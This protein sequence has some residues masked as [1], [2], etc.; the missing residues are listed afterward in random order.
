MLTHKGT[1]PLQTK[2]LK[3][4]RFLTDDYIGMYHNWANQEEVTRFLTWQPHASEEAT[5]TLLQNW[6]SQYENDTYYNWVIEYQGKTIGNISVVSGN[7]RSQCAELGYCIGK[8]YWNKGIMTEA[9]TEIVRFLFDEVGYHR[10]EIDH[11]VK[12]PGSGRVAQKCGF[13]YE[14]TKR[15]CFRNYKGERLDISFYGL[16]KEEWEENKKSTIEKKDLR[17]SNR[18]EPPND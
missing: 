2:R 5:K 12:N 15:Q 1:I 14:G 3:L 10:L 7:D 9:V 11:A 6:V 16:L 17:F 13:T 18:T 8:A 4:R